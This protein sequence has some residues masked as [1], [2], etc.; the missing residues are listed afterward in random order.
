ME[1]LAGLQRAQAP[2]DQHVTVH[3]FGFGEGHS[4]ELLQAVA[5]AQSGVYYYIRT[6]DDIAAG[7]GDGE[8]FGRYDL[9]CAAHTAPEEER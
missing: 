7:F 5:E 8:A 9:A 3:T 4:V 2:T 6:V 1:I